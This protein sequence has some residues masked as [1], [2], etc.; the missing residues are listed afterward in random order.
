MKDRLH[1]V[2]L[3]PKEMNIYGDTGNRLI[4]KKRLEWRGFEV[5]MSLVGI[6]QEIPREA[7][8]IIGGGGQDAGQSVVQNDLQKKSETLHRLAEEGVVMLMVCGLYQ[9]FGKKFVTN[10]NELIK[11]IG[12]LP[13]ETTAGPT[14]LI[15]NTIYESEW[16]Q[17]V[18]YE[19]HSGLTHLD[20]K[21][22]ALAKVTKGAGNNGKDGTEGCR[23]H[24]VFGTYSHG[25]ILSK[26]PAFADELI[27]LAVIRRHG[28]QKLKKLDDYLEHEAAKVAM[29]RP[30]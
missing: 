18:G 2:H 13:L 4:L 30:R 9:L 16:G 17:I 6:G 3:Y 27:R 5:E 21:K 15:G 19:N 14:R 28:E 10:E 24:N 23:I 12:L 22:H 26:N 11:G 29:A 20:D 7:D 8:I 1:L 25:P